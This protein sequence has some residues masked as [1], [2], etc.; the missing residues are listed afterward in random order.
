MKR[1]PEL[2]RFA[3]R[4]L[5][6]GV[7]RRVRLLVYSL[8]RWLERRRLTMAELT[9]DHFRQFLARP[10]RVRVATRIRCQYGNLLR[11]YLR[12]LYDRGLA[13]FVP[14][15]RRRRPLELP[16][17]AREFLASLAPTHRSSTRHR[18]AYSLRKLYAWLTARG[19]EPERLTRSE[20]APWFQ[21]LDASGLRVVSRSHILIDVRAYLHWLSEQRRMRTAPD[22]LIRGNDLPKLPQYLP[23]P[24]TAHADR[25]LQHRLANA[26]EP[27]AW[28]L[29]LMRRTGLRIGELRNLEYHCIRADQRRP[30]LKVPLGKLN[31][32]RLVPLD[33]VSVELIRRLQS[34]GLRSRSWL[35]PGLGGARM[36][37]DRIRRLL[38]SH[39]HDLSDPVRI[40][41][42]RLRHTYATEMLGAGM[43]LPGLMRLLGHRDYHMTLRYTAIMSETVSK[44]Y[45]EA[46][47]QLATKYQL[48]TRTQAAESAPE[49]GRIL[50][51]LS[52]LLRKHLSSRQSI[53]ALLKR[54]ARLRHDVLLVL[55]P[56]R[57]QP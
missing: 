2:P 33:A 40:T 21:A 45:D 51:D 29:L 36:S 41:S 11:G 43:S 15:S 7:N 44:E 39:C 3:Q 27:G 6:T 31:N 12:W 1:P 57:H 32:E 55:P 30:L 17:L 25:E 24:L 56:T 19:L 26:N 38:K 34:T 42:H 8:H 22:D 46:L 49:P 5:R 13:G 37:Y 23:R 9:P 28:A 48:P 52:R 53:R 35:V 4:F 50:E 16:V 54:I 14:E 20:I 18:Y 10:H 47:A